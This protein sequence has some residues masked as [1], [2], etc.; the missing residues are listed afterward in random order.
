MTTHEYRIDTYH[1]CSMMQH[2]ITR[3]LRRWGQNLYEAYQK[4]LV[5]LNHLAFLDPSG[6]VSSWA[7][8]LRRGL[9]ERE[10][11]AC[12]DAVLKALELQETLKFLEVSHTTEDEKAAIAYFQEEDRFV[13]VVHPRK[14]TSK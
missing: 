10:F 12:N 5:D 7:N 6:T 9:E 13:V 11:D 14:E 1:L 2:R 4:I 3:S 8:Q